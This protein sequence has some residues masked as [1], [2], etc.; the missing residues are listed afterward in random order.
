MST[1]FEPPV[2]SWERKLREELCFA[3]LNNLTTNFEPGEFDFTCCLC[4]FFSLSM[5]ELSL[6][7]LY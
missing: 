4:F 3:K 2:L 1:T 6:N 5:S 7:N